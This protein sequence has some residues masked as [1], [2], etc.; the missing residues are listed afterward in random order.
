MWKKWFIVFVLISLLVMPTLA[1]DEIETNRYVGLEVSRAEDG[2][3]VLG[4]E[5]ASITLVVFEDFLCPHCQNYQETIHEFVEKYVS[6]GV[7]K[8]EFRMLPV[9]SEVYSPMIF[10]IAECSNEL[11]EGS[12]FTVHDYLFELGEQ[13]LLNDET[14]SLVADEFDFDQEA[15]E[16]CML[17]ATQWE[18]D[19]ELA[20]QLGIQGTPGVRMR[21]DGSEPEVIT[22]SGEVIER[23]AIPIEVLS[24]VV[25]GDE[26]YAIGAPEPVLRSDEFFQDVTLIAGDEACSA[27]CWMGVSPG[28]DWDTVLTTL[29]DAGLNNF[30]VVNENG[31]IWTGENEEVCCQAVSFEGTTLDLLQLQVAPKMTIGKVIEIYGEPT[32]VSGEAVSKTQAVMTIFFPDQNLILGIYIEDGDEGNLDEA[33][34][35]IQVVY[36]SSEMMESVIGSVPLHSWDGYQSFAAYMEGEFEIVPQT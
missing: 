13:R 18:T 4:D 6:T 22:V 19:W 33:S 7:A 31:A 32:Y 11:S 23:G 2:A 29:G 34:E 21:L 20:R 25:E 10:R 1:Q 26:L 24:G 16:T 3:F 28:D 8:F 5:E 30:E 27:P 15:L 17:T 12:F 9:I 14:A 36:L 35:I